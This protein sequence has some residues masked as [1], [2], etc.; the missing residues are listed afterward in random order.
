MNRLFIKTLSRSLQEHISLWATRRETLVWLI[1]GV[2]QIGTVNLSR[3][4][5]HV[6]SRAQTTS[7][8]RRL[9]RFFQNVRFDQADIARLI[10]HLFQFEGKPWHLALDRT[11]W[12]F[13]RCEINI[14]VLAIIHDK[15]AIPL[16]W[17]VLGK[18][19]NSNAD[20][21]IDLIDCLL[22]TFPA[23]PIASL[24]GDREFVGEKWM[25]WLCDNHIA[26][27]LRLRK[28][29]KIS[30]EDYAEV[31]LSVHAN[32]LKRKET[33]H[34]KGLWSLGND[35]AANHR[36]KI[37]LMRLNS[38]ELLIIASRG[39]KARAA[40]PLYRKRWAIETLFSCLKSRGLGLEDTHMKAPEKLSTLMAVLAIAVC[41]AYKA[42]LWAVRFKPLRKKAHG[43]LQHSLFALGLRALRNCLCDLLSTKAGNIFLRL[44]EQ[45]IPRNQCIREF[46]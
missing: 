3:L 1:L 29:M 41:F 24:Y 30:N 9:E 42:G 25:G 10:V 46:L 32:G 38:G 13:G 39:V 19:G 37:A 17:S 15:M 4:A 26:F 18:A 31:A 45:K 35:R 43:R 34:L 7:V 8:H 2:V 22:K 33:R 11:N 6:N 16:F 14:L 12:K 5:G 20:E 23:Q 40:L 28:N 44:M 27:V 21:R 36:V